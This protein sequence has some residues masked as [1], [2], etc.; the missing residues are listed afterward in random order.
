M[1]A[2]KLS[3][4]KD[5]IKYQMPKLTREV[6]RSDNCLERFFEAEQV[7]QRKAFLLTKIHL[8]EKFD[9]PGGL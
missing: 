6:E 3:R 1:F 9:K 8:Y 4:L 5:K 7:N 2:K